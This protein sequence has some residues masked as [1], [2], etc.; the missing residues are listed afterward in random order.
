MPDI[1]QSRAIDHVLKLIA[2]EG[3]SGDEQRVADYI[4]DALTEVGVQKT[5][6]SF[7]SAHRKSSADGTTGNLIV[8]LKGT[9]RAPRRLLMAHMDTV[10]LAVKSKPVR[11]GDWIRP[12]DSN[13]ALGG[14]NRSGCAV[15]LSTVTEILRRGL[16]HPPLTLLFTVQE[17]IGLRGARNL[18]T[19]KL[20][21]PALCFNWDGR[22]PALLIH[23]A[24][25][26][27]NLSIQIE[28][29]ASHAGVHPE[30]G[31]NAAVVASTAIAELQAA[32]WHGLIEKGRQ[33]GASNVGMIYGGA[34]TNVVMPDLALEAEVRSHQSG[35]RDRIVK[36]FRKAFQA[37]VSGIRNQDGQ[38]ATL[39]F[40]E[41]VRYEAFRI[42]PRSECVR[43]ASDAVRSIGLTP[44]TLIADGGL[45]ANW[46]TAHGFPT[47]TL[48]CGQHH[49]HTVKEVLNIPEYLAGC[50][51][52]MA[53]ALGS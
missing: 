13:T 51:I 5:S 11:D 40:D 10:P 1:D 46:L 30:D 18:T 39:T 53:I 8:N 7:D 29:I 33:R 15:V 16:P 31:V 3:G 48:G 50:Q 20:G 14:D 2:I 47:V 24:I 43:V 19:S 12:A 6:M 26:A 35:F 42:S 28:G 52:A 25:G 27:S 21:R 34:A 44:E 38:T 36:Q 4:I 41:D 32:G 23:G 49:I 22:D 37:A 17:E 9:V 45:D